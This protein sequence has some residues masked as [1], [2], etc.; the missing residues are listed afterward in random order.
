MDR[1]SVLLDC[2]PGTLHG[3]DEK[4][5]AWSDLTHVVISH[6][7]NDHV[8]DLGATLFA[9]KHAAR[10]VRTA[11][12]TLVGPVGFGAFLVRLADA[13]GEHV[14]DPGFELE[15]A[16]VAVD[17]PYVDSLAGFRLRACPTPHTEESLAY[18]IE[19]EWGAVGYT[20]DTGPSHDVATFLEGCSVVVAECALA[21]PPTMDRHLS[22][23][24]LTEMVRR[25]RPELLVVTHVY[26]PQTPEQAVASVRT[27]YDGAVV[28]GRDGLRVALGSLGPVVDPPPTAV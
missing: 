4:G 18:R 2:G 7:H 9:L 27:V 20:G 5:V 10:P 21:D 1:A 14:L 12:L 3:F 6:Y 23:T 11:P 22:P 28:A 19:G 17:A 15:V 13:L 8:G 25:A 16:E 26:P 24:T